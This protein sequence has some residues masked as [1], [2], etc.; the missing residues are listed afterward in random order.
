MLLDYI[1]LNQIIILV[2]INL[3]TFISLSI[4]F[5][6]IYLNNNFKENMISN[7]NRVESVN[8]EVE[9][10]KILPERKLTYR[11]LEIIEFIKQG[12]TNKEIATILCIS[13]NTVKYHIKVIY[14]N[15]GISRRT[16]L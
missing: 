16:E 11:Q 2:I 1:S 15:L 3:I 6:R 12:K 13:E 5:Y 8:L 9:H 7:T 10:E 4:I 14:N